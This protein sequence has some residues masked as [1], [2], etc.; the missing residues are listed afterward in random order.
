[1]TMHV[2]RGE[3]WMQRWI[4][5]LALLAAAAH[6]H[7]VTLGAVQ[8]KVTIGRPLELVVMA[9]AGE[10]LPESDACPQAEVSYGDSRLTAAEL[11]V[12]G[13]TQGQ[14]GWRV[15]ASRPV[16][17]PLVTLLFRVGCGAGYSR[18]YVLLADQDSKVAPARPA[19]RTRVVAEPETSPMLLAPVRLPPARARP[20]GIERLPAKIRPSPGRE[21]AA[22]RPQSVDPGLSASQVAAPDRTGPRLELEL[23]EQ[24][25]E[26]MPAVAGEEAAAGRE[27]RRELEDLRAEQARTRAIVA[28]LQRELAEARR[29]RWQDPLVLA[30]LGLSAASLLALAWGWLRQ[31]RQV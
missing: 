31:R 6:G 20:A 3:W 19:A 13:L 27:F 28:G 14:P 17:E 26:K 10:A 7:A 2:G 24:G 16:N 5:A 12:T 21:A 25:A 15:R 29:S 1:M 23:L 9:A 11:S 4:G 22:Q 8:G 30:L 18:S